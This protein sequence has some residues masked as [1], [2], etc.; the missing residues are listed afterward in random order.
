MSYTLKDCIDT[1]RLQCNDADASTW[2][3]PAFLPFANEGILFLFTERPECRLT[4]AGALTAYVAL[5]AVGTAVPLSDEYKNALIE[6]LIYRFF[7]A[8][9]GDTRDKARAAEHLQRFQELIGP[10]K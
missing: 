5:T 1:A 3:D 10:S 9:D 2:G 8:D 4:S 7:C 6:Y